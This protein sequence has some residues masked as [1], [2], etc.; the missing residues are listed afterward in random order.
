MKLAYL[1]TD[2]LAYKVSLE[3]QLGRKQSDLYHHIFE[4]EATPIMAASGV[5]SPRISMSGENLG[6]NLEWMT[7]S[8]IPQERGGLAVISWDRNRPTKAERIIGELVDQGGMIGSA[9]L[10]LVLENLE[11]AYYSPAWWDALSADQRAEVIRVYKSTF[12]E[13]PRHVGELPAVDW[14]LR[15]HERL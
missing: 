5:F 10:R 13:P 9:L 3:E 7:V 6:E 11:N 15:R 2:L 4:F 14:V 8:V 12:E 1:A